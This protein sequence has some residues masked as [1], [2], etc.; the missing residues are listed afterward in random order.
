MI[1][2][3]IDE[4]TEPLAG[5]H[6]LGCLLLTRSFFRSRFLGHEFFQLGGVEKFLKFRDGCAE[7]FRAS[8][9]LRNLGDVTEVGEGRDFQ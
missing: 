8:E 6:G 4:R 9:S 1:W 2:R 3:R 7:L 5:G